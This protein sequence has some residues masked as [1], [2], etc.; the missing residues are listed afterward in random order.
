MQQGSVNK[1]ED[2]ALESVPDHARHGWRAMT[3]NTTGIVTTLVQIFISALLTTVAGF[4]I[5]LEAGLFVTIVGTIFGWGAGHIAYRTGYS[6]TVMS[7]KF[8]FGVK[9]SVL[10][11]AAIGF[12]IIGFLALENVLLYKGFLFYL[13]RADSLETQIVIYGIMTI[14]WIVLT[15][16]GF[17]FIS[18][19]SSITLLLFLILLAWMGYVVLHTSGLSFA[20]AVNFPSQLPPKALAAMGITSP[21]EAFF[22]CV[23]I[24]IGSAGALA[25]IDADQ[26]RYSKSS[27]DIGIAA[28]A[29]NLAMLPFMALAGGLIIHAGMPALV[30]YYEHVQNMTP[31]AAHQAVLKDPG[32]MAMAFVIFGGVAGAILMVFAQSKAQVLN[33]YTASL[34]LTNLFDAFNLRISRLACVVLANVIGIIMLY[35]NILAKV[36]S[37]LNFMGVVNTV[38]ITIIMLDFFVI[39]KFSERLHEAMDGEA[40]NWAGIG[41]AILAVVIS[42]LVPAH[43][44]PI[45]FFFSVVIAALLYVPSRLFFLSRVATIPSVTIS[46][47]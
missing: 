19:I 41:S 33:T 23:N 34:S 42:Q 4:W 18:R 46:D 10:V 24:Y 39:R 12:M 7:R 26:G 13:K 6:S 32:S 30:H 8:G 45:P 16:Y 2:H 17:K 28:L 43:F 47:R 44:C 9:G 36:A 29:G 35:G 3:W 14:A 25:F 20:A 40:F 21:I 5:T 27:Y 1:I 38:L 11:S 15:A 37:W 31:G 22:F